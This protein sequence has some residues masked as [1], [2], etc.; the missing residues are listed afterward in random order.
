MDTDAFRRKRK[1][2]GLTQE[3]LA[4]RLGINRMTIIRYESGESPVPKS[5]EMALKLIEA[6]ERK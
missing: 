1:G 5:V 2:L 4:K 3:N 6:E